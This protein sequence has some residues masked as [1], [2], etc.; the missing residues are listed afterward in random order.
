M[1]GPSIWMGAFC[2]LQKEARKYTLLFGDDLMGDIV[3][4]NIAK[5]VPAPRVVE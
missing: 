1:M 4:S 3:R 5:Q 2:L